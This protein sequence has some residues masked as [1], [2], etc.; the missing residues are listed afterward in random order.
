MPSVSRAMRKLMAVA[1]H[2]PEEVS[3]KNRG[4]L[5]MSHQQLHEF[6][7]TKEKGLPEHVRKISKHFDNHEKTHLR[8]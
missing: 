5:S 1:E 8:A 3:A 2:H 4:V 6:S 7:S